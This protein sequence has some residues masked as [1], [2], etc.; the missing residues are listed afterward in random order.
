MAS[1]PI[2][3]SSVQTGHIGNSRV[4]P[5]FLQCFSSIF[6]TG[7]LS[8]ASVEVGFFAPSSASKLAYCIYLIMFSKKPPFPA[9]PDLKF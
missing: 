6:T 3:K 2:S 7:S 8:K 1:F 9:R 5:F 4:S